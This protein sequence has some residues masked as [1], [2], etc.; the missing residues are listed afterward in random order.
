MLYDS[1][2]NAGEYFT[3]YYLEELLPGEVTKT[4]AK[5]WNETDRGT[6][7]VSPR[8]R[9]LD[10]RTPYQKAR[11][12]IVNATEARTDE[13]NGDGAQGNSP[14]P[15]SSASSS[16][17]RNDAADQRAADTPPAVGERRKAALHAWH[18]D[19]LAGLGYTPE[20]ETVELT[21][22][23]ETREISLAYQSKTVFA[24]ECDF[25]ELA[26]DAADLGQV[27]VLQDGFRDAA[28]LAD[29]LFGIDGNAP[30]YVLLLCGGVVV[31]ADIDSFR[32][33]RYLAVSIGTVLERNDKPE[34]GLATA[35][36]ARE[37]LEPLDAAEPDATGLDNLVKQ[38]RT[39]AQGVSKSLREGL[40]RSVEII[41]KEVLDCLR[42][43]EFDWTDFFTDRE[44][45][46]RLAT[47]SLRYL[48]RILFLLFAEARPEL[49]IL[50]T[51]SPDYQSGYSIARLGR[52]VER[53]LGEES[54]EGTYLYESLALLF[55]RVND[56]YRFEGSDGKARIVFEPLQSRL[57]DPA[58]ITLIGND[59]KPSDDD[60]VWPVDTR[61][62]NKA[63]HRVLRMLM[64]DDGTLSGKRGRRGQ[65]QFISYAK[66]GINQLGAVYEGLMSY[67]G[68]IARGETLY[69][70]A[71]AKDL[72][73]NNGQSKDGSWLIPESE[74]DEYPADVFVSVE[75]PY[76]GDRSPVTYP[77]GSFVYRLAGRDRETS[78]S[79]YTPLSLTQTTVELTVRQLIEEHGGQVAAKDLLNW[80]ILEPAL[81]S[82]AF[83]NEAINQVAAKY[84][85]LR[86]SETG[87]RVDPDKWEEELRKVKAYIALH[88]SYGVD[89]NATATELAEVSLWLNVM[90]PGLKAPWF[91]LHLRHGNSLIGGRR[92]TY[93]LKELAP[94]KG[95]PFWYDITPRHDKLSEIPAGELP[96]DRIHHFLLPSKGWAAI[97]DHKEAKALVGDD[98][99]ALGKWRNSFTKKLNKKQLERAQR[100]ARQVE[101][102]WGLV[103]RRLELSEEAIARDI[104]V[105][106]APELAEHSGN[107]AINKEQ[108]LVDLH[109]HG[110]P[111]WRLKKLMDTWCALWFW[112]VGETELLI[113]PEEVNPAPGGPS[114]LRDL[115][116]WFKY[117]EAIVG[118]T[119]PGDFFGKELPADLNALTDH[120]DQLDAWTG[121]QHYLFLEQNDQ[122]FAFI[123]ELDRIVR[124]QHFFHWE[125]QYAHVF[126][127]GGFDLQ[128][129]NPPWYRPIWDSDG[130]MSEADPHY[131]L[132]KW[133]DAQKRSRKEALLAEEKV[134]SYFLN[135][136]ANHAGLSAFVGHVT[137]YNLL[138]GTQPNFYRCFMVRTWSNAKLKGTIG[139]IHP[140]T[141][142]SGAKEGRLRSG[143]YGRL[144]VHGHMVNERK[145]FDEVHNLMEYGLHIYSSPQEISFTH[146]SW[147][148]EASVITG[149]MNHDGHGP[150]PGLKFDGGWDIRPH[151]GRAI[152]VDLSVLAEWNK[153]PG[154]TDDPIEETKILYPVSVAELEPIAKLAEVSHRFGDLGADIS[155][156]YHES[157]DK[158]AGYFIDIDR[159]AEISDKPAAKAVD[160]WSEVILQG[161]HFA[162]S[163]PFFKSPRTPLKS[164]KDWE[165]FDITKLPPNERPITN[166]RRS[167]DLELYRRKQD[168]WID[169]ASWT[170]KKS[171]ALERERAEDWLQSK[172]DPSGTEI[173]EAL[174]DT[175]LMD[176]SKRPYT[177]F[178]RM[179][180]REMIQVTNERSLYVSLIPP[181]PAHVDAVHTGR[182]P[183]DLATVAQVG[184]CSSLLLDYYVRVTGT[185]HLKAGSAR[186]FPSVPPSHPLASALQLRTL[187]LNCLT[188]SYAPV[189]E[190]YCNVEE[191]SM[192]DWAFP[193]PGVAPLNSVGPQW[194]YETPLRTDFERRAALIEIDVLSAL[195]LGIT[196]EQLKTIYA[197]RYVVL[198]GREEAT[199][200]DSAGNK[201]CGDTKAAG[202]K[203]AH[204]EGLDGLVNAKLPFQQLSS[205]L[206]GDRDEGPS[207]F[208]RFPES[209]GLAYYRANRLGMPVDDEYPQGVNGNAEADTLGEY[210]HAHKVFS[211][212]L[213]KLTGEKS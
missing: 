140:D 108:V 4:H 94:A 74:V 91:G 98:A 129:G 111:Y 186:N 60:Y 18:L 114:H 172:A 96:E 1:I 80:K 160:S 133:N 197:A 73:D 190:E 198:G 173:P 159:S 97:A 123:T 84:L 64:I 69:E 185:S 148:Y 107:L 145:L 158:K 104:D 19:L 26:G 183:D 50:P 76:T 95:K 41:A 162:I 48:Y 30:K 77:D 113:G 37:M 35:L 29:W 20:P 142:L 51:D 208:P 32:E 176:E 31:T 210:A 72:K 206:A 62:R 137:T 9:L 135:E 193:W 79:F 3:N 196:A 192:E 167:V 13:A 187:R 207:G 46:D 103:R 82:G 154:V 28:K 117:C 109:R 25:R 34:A 44:F 63:L 120:E 201:L 125:L 138:A 157:A 21:N 10:L 71:Q 211:E 8:K 213:A 27:Q 16:S 121:W 165:P 143:A 110:S 146:L 89:L 203:Q 127:N 33:G 177:D 178:W 54:R 161:P 168:R 59:L 132:S 195:I 128:V 174:V 66:L 6:D 57:F 170:A 85:E 179:A 47:E 175:F 17:E 56:G 49:R 204:T 12:A 58:S 139:L 43:Q 40:R 112:P 144:R 23:G 2:L 39:Q 118:N 184:F 147:A 78:A 22:C 68:R 141:H 200:F 126:R 14:E 205:Y 105:W 101:Y 150:L 202:Y 83:L 119:L 11:V 153:L 182:L 188:E 7:G 81:G 191:I 116:E 131:V 38:S 171:D 93:S 156:G 90:Y 194:G 87:K 136:V 180:W 124:E 55:R 212:R 5:A 166:Y 130:I 24:V 92:E 209:S 65:T 199:W 100:L 86:Q 75:D 99:K 181:G 115:D 102:L 152:Q 45:A 15:G 155:S 169:Y 42:E 164:N 36:V 88:N 151:A 70:V 163:T 52:T 149:S 61:L 134:R 106:G 189:W 67:T 53:E 122:K